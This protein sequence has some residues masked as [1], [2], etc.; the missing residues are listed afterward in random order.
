LTAAPSARAFLAASSVP[1][2]AEG[3]VLVLGTQ[4][5]GVTELPACFL[6]LGADLKPGKYLIRVTC[7]SEAD[8]YLLLSRVLPGR[9]DCRRVFL[10]QR[11]DQVGTDG[12]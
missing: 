4:E 12:E 10:D 7:P 9:T 11:G 5:R 2:Q 6:T 3:T 8:R 1:E